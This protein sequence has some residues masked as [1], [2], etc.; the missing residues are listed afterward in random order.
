MKTK[1]L[2]FFAI[3]AMIAGCKNSQAPKATPT[4][5]SI[6][7]T[8][9]YPMLDSANIWEYDKVAKWQPSG[10]AIVYAHKVYL[11]AAD[12]YANQ[13]DAKGSLPLFV[14]ALRIAPEP[15]MYLH[16]SEAL[17]QDTQYELAGLAATFAFRDS[18]LSADAAMVAARADAHLDNMEFYANLAEALSSGKFDVKEVAAYSDF[19]RIRDDEDFKILLAKYDFTNEQRRH[20]LLDLF[21]IN[22]KHEELPF[23]IGPD[24]LR[25]ESNQEI[26][27]MFDDLIPE[28]G[29]LTA[30]FSRNPEQTFQYVAALPSGPGF[31]TLVYRSVNYVA[32]ITDSMDL[33]PYTYYLMTIDTAGQ[34]IDKIDLACACSPLHIKTA[35]IDTT[36]LIAV[37]SIRQTYRYNPIDSGYE[38]NEVIKR[39]PTGTK[40][41]RINS[42][43]KIEEQDIATAHAD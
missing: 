14:R 15:V 42:K 9:E 26:D 13:K 32:M 39:E 4:A 11:N 35:A 20:A 7:L 28:L 16:Y 34:N 12:R 21:R 38:H 41:Y 37:Q 2:L 1:I 3:A 8:V 22:F 23:E 40:Y 17:L 6:E 33:P 30:A 5:P 25:V 27:Y 31:H 10:D 36:G 29:G 24:S 19:D 43:G 18:T